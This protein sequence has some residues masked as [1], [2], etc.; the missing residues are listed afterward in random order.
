[1]MGVG[2]K[3]ALGLYRSMC[4]KA[5]NPRSIA[6]ANGEFAF[7]D[8]LVWQMILQDPSQRSP[9]LSEVLG[10]IDVRRELAASS[11]RIQAL[12]QTRIETESAY[13]PLRGKAVE[14]L[15]RSAQ[16]KDGVLSLRLSQPVTAT[17]VQSFKRQTI[18]GSILDRHRRPMNP[19]TFSFSGDVISVDI[20]EANVPRLIPDIK[21]YL[22]EGGN[23]YNRDEN[24]R[25]RQREEAAR[26]LIK[27]RLEDERTRQATIKRANELI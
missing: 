2:A 23:Q 19:H 1:M 27:K 6:D 3:R 11:S 15:P 9:D 14:L 5:A 26:E 10:E 13:D 20:D 18:R 4:T 21:Q 24:T 16:Y 22:R 12:E 8:D 17:W 25:Q 7:L